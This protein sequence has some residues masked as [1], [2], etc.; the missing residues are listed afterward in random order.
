MVDAGGQSKSAEAADRGVRTGRSIAHG[1]GRYDRAAAQRQD[2][3]QRHLPQSGAL[4]PRPFRQGQWLALAIPDAGSADTVGKTLLAL[5][6]CTVLAPSER[7]YLQRGRRPNK[8]TD[9]ARQ[10][11]LMVRRWM[12][13]CPTVVVADS[14]FAALE[15]LDAT[16]H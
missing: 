12:P 4:K 3:R 10:L 2:C 14:T 6:F 8:L 9:R 16:R 11:L 1:I 15:L 5:P 13:E 7:Y